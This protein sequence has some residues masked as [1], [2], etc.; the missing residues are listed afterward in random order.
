M[1]FAATMPSGPY[2]EAAL[3]PLEPHSVSLPAFADVTCPACGRVLDKGIYATLKTR[4]CTGGRR[5]FL[6]LRRCNER[7]AHV[8]LK[9]KT[10][11]AHWI[12]APV[13]PTARFT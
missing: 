2:R 1:S 13:D 11:G 6:W 7:R 9:H 8:H 3:V 12:C 10:C 4:A 5:L